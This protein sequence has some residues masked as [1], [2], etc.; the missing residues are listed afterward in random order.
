MVL[1]PTVGKILE[2]K[3]FLTELSAELLVKEELGGS[4]TPWE[5]VH[6]NCSER[7]AGEYMQEG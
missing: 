5:T 2:N 6:Y 7:S 3:N 4:S 1:L